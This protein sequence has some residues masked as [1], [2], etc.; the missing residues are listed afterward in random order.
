MIDRPTGKRQP[1]V[2][3]GGWIAS[4]IGLEAGLAYLSKC[5]VLCDARRHDAPIVFVNAAFTTLTGYSSEEAVGRNCRF[6]QGP[7]TDRTSVELIRQAINDGVGIQCELINYRKK[8]EPYW[9]KFSIDPIRDTNGGISHFISIQHDADVERATALGLIEAEQRLA[10]LIE[11]IPGYVFRRVLHADRTLSFPFLS[12]SLFRTLGLPDDTNLETR[13]FI[14]YMRPDEH[15]ELVRSVIQSGLDLTTVRSEVRFIAPSGQEFWFRSVS[16]PRAEAGGIVIWDGVAVDITAEKVSDAKIFYLAHHDVLTTLPNRVLFRAALLD[17]VAG[18]MLR[19]PD[20]FLLVIDLDEFQV[21]NEELGVAFGDLILAE[22]GRRLLA[23]ADS[24]GGSAARLGGD[25]FALLLPAANGDIN[26]LALAH[27][28]HQE[29]LHPHVISGRTFSTE[30][31]VGT[32]SYCY[33]D[34]A[35]SGDPDERVAELMKRADL[36]LHRAKQQGSGSCRVYSPEID[37]RVQNRV[38]LRASLQ[39]GL[40]HDQFQLHYQ[41]LVDLVTGRIVGAEALVRWNHPE[42]GLQRP[43][44]FIPYAES[45]GLIV[46]LGAWVI[47]QAMVQGQLWRQRG[48]VPPRI[49]INLSAVQLQRP[50]FLAAVERSLSETGAKAED[51]EFELTEGTLVSAATEVHRQLDSLRGAGFRL[52]IDDFG[53]GYSTLK[54]L[55][56]FAIDKV[57]ID[58]TFVRNLVINSNDALIIRAIMELSRSLNLDVVAEGIETIMQRNFLIEV[59]CE[60]GQGYLLSM[61]LAAEDF[62]WLLEKRHLLLP[63]RPDSSNAVR[64]E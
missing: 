62:G 38:A 4:G 44:L 37:D 60:V 39:D 42:L 55:R 18:E 48:L 2:A 29:L 61:P 23:F 34:G 59:G 3:V 5:A 32:V 11:N 8:G 31:C 14:D 1:N 17:A 47:R 19:R 13:G 45:S 57:K 22:I 30:C 41:P 40:S 58:Q 9:S 54:S 28:V 56:D 53:T 27:A 10:T 21:F 12:R 16:K 63:A 35:L 36:A 25:E 50:G 6:L 26:E 15:A 64:Q 20:V 49:A 33:K 7:L 51:Y 43:D 46:P 52:A 24:R